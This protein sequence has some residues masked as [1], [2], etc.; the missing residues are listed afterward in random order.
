MVL[1]GNS[2]FTICDRITEVNISGMLGTVTSDT[3]IRGRP[4]DE[5][6]TTAILDST[7]ELLHRHGIEDLKVGDIA[8]DAG[9]GLATIYRRWPNKEELVAAALRSRLLPPVEE[10]GD[11]A[12][13]LR[14]L[15]RAVAQD[16][17]DMDRGLMDVLA[18]TTKEPVLA[19]AFSEGILGTARPRFRRYLA[20]LLG[21]DSPHLDLLIDGFAGALIVRAGLL[22]DFESPGDF[23]DDVMALIDALL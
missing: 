19:D 12:T 16:V 15:L 9:C 13:D 14:N 7:R 23:V 5:E 2:H 1:S 10:T 6:R 18:A 17:A 22:D 4:R 21:A 11:S 8:A 3:T 20:D